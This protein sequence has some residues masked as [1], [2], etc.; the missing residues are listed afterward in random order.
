[1]SVCLI[2][3]PDSYIGSAECVRATARGAVGTRRAHP[4][5]EVADQAGRCRVRRPR[6]PPHPLTRGRHRSLLVRALGQR[7]RDRRLIFDYQNPHDHIVAPG[8]RRGVRA[9]PNLGA[10]GILQD[11]ESVIDDTSPLRT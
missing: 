7:D 4:C 8:P 1:M 3:D 10:D 6:A 5:P 9:F 2:V 11:D